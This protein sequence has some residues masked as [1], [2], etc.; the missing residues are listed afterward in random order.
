MIDSTMHGHVLIV[1]GGSAGITVAARLC[2]A[3]VR[4]V[5]LIEPETVHY[6]QPLFTL[7]GAGVT[8]MSATKHL[9]SDVIPSGV[10][11]FKDKAKIFRPD[12]NQVE[13]D[14]GKVIS[15]DYLVVCPGIQVDW[16][17]IEG[18]Q[19]QIGHGG[20]CSNYATEYVSYTWE[21]IKSFKQGT[22]IFTFPNTPI[23]CAGAPQKIMY[24]A[25]DYFRK[26]GI[27]SKCRIVFASAGPRIFGVEKYA[28]T[29]R[30][31]I[32]SRG[33]ETEFRHN[34][35]KVDA[36]NKVAIFENVETKETK[37]LTYDLLHVSPP[38]SAP[39]FIKQSPLANDAGWVEVDKYTL[40]HTRF[41]NIFS[42]G[43]ASSLPTSKTG[44]AIRKQAPVLVENLLALMNGRE[45]KARYDGYSSCP[46]VTGYGRL[47]LA[48][49]DYDGKPAETFPF[50]QSKERFSMYLLKKYVLPPLYWFG[51]LKGRV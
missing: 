13:L 45:L 38:M 51:M 3:G 2:N 49:F 33:I 19:G 39:D 12:E 9:M 42:L 30:N 27:R 15:Y 35:I 6:Y 50:D 47:I 8:P 16:D 17:K 1:G 34:L 46:L 28:K 5:C 11:W 25:E 48:E 14:S 10:N 20:I 44:A 7:V 26:V 36:A 31:I 21:A 43:D 32:E 40:Q 23:K 22:A 29:L 37:Q 4:G 41:K 18:L 24:L